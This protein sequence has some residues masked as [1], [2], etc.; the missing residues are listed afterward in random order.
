MG[1]AVNPDK[2]ARVLATFR[3]YMLGPTRF[4]NLLSCFELGI[5]DVLKAHTHSRLT[6]PQIGERVGAAP[7]AV[8]QLLHLLVKEDLLSYD[9]ASSSYAL[10]G[11][12][13]LSSDEFGRV[14]SV[15]NMIKVVCLRQLYYLSDSVRAGKVVGLKQLYGFDGTLYDAC[16]RHDE[17]RAAWGTMMDQVTSFID[18]WFFD[19]VEIPGH[20]KVL[21]VA[22]NTGLGA[23]L[24]YRFKRADGLHVTCFDLPEKQAAAVANFTAE[25]VQDHCEFVGGDVFHGLPAGFDIVMIK[26]FLDMFDRDN[27]LQILRRAHEALNPGGQVYI[28]V[29]IY[30]ENLKTAHSVDIFPAYFLGCTMGQGGPQKLSTYQQ[31]IEASGFKVTKAMSQDLAAMPPDVVAVHGILCATKL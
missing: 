7:A 27:V 21:D 16:S 20:T 22:G 24:A 17:L 19:N 13:H 12:A 18:P 6:A 2:A 3:E 28:L 26:H 29:P 9:E 10:D 25:G 31:W 11:L 1:Q 23:I 30:P 5:V 14:L 4:M 15:M 8:E